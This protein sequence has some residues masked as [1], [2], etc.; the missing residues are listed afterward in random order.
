MVKNLSRVALAAILKG[1]KIWERNCLKLIV[2]LTDLK[3]R[4]I[5]NLIYSYD[6]VATINH[7]TQSY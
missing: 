2:R 3:I 7:H 5:T 4:K 6:E 1:W